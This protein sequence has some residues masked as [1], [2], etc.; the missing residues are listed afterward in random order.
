MDEMEVMLINLM[1][2]LQPMELSHKNDFHILQA[3]VMFLRVQINE[4]V[5][6]FGKNI[7]ENQI[8]LLMLERIYKQLKIKFIIMAQLQTC[9]LFMNRF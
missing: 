1:N 5:N 2:M 4:L 3:M 6:K 8:Q 9:L 7:N